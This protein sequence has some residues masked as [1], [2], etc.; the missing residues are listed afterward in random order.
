MLDTVLN[1]GIV[2]RVVK[3]KNGKLKLLD[4]QEFKL[5]VR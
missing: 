3:N 1:Q 4:H 5:K 2:G